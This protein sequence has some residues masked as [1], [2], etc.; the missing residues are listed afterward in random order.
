MVGELPEG[1]VETVQP[2]GLPLAGSG[3]FTPPAVAEEVGWLSVAVAS[4]P[5]K[6]PATAV[7]PFLQLAVT[8]TAAEPKQLRPPKPLLEQ[9]SGRVLVVLRIVTLG[10][11][12]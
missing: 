3:R 7:S 11:P 8:R 2:V 9:L 4:V 1:N 6:P 12:Q 10:A 5:S